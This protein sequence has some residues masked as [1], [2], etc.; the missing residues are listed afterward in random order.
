MTVGRFFTHYALGLWFR[1]G[2]VTVYVMDGRALS[3]WP[4][5][6]VMLL[7]LYFG[8]RNF[9]AAVAFSDPLTGILSQVAYLF[10]WLFLPSPSG[11][12]FVLVCYSSA[13][14]IDAWALLHLKDSF[15]FG[16]PTFVSWVRSGP[17]RWFAHPQ[18]FA[19]S[20]IYL[21]FV[22]QALD[23]R[24]IPAG[25]LLSILASAVVWS[26]ELRFL[27]SIEVPNDNESVSV[28]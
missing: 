2:L 27:S 15:T 4:V 16:G 18:W 12:P 3:L 20:L 8:L 11:S 26:L 7:E 9:R 10:G 17:Y 25:L 6:V 23:A 28:S 24:S 5:L 19:R 22:P 14:I 1:V 21:A 13:L